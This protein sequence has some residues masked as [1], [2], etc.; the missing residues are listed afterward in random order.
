M[1]YSDY[2]YLFLMIGLTSDQHYPDMLLRI[3][4]LIEANMQQ[5]GHEN[6]D[7]GKSICYFRLNAKV[8]VKP[9]ML[10]LPVVRSMEGV[11]PS[12]LLESKDWCTYDVN[13]YRGYS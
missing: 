10:T 5:S 2:M 8:R 4:D 1:Y 9:L 7:L 13:I 3:G 6:F 12:S 11:D